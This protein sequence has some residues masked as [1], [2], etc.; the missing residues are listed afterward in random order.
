MFWK[1]KITFLFRLI[2]KWI[3]FVFC[4]IERAPR[5][6][7]NWVYCSSAYYNGM[8]FRMCIWHLTLRIPSTVY[9]VRN[10]LHMY[11]TQTHKNATHTHTSTQTATLITKWL[12]PK[13]NA[14]RICKIKNKMNLLLEMLRTADSLAVRPKPNEPKRNK[15]CNA[16]KKYEL[17]ITFTATHRTAPHQTTLNAVCR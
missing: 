5:I 8:V 14:K 6:A 2:I 11:Q 1:K 9:T 4:R 17:A 13:K 7:Y 10:T 15:K 16:Y 3:S 12:Q